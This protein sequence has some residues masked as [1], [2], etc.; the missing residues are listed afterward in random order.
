MLEIS[1]LKY[2]LLIYLGMDKMV[3]LLRN[4][5]AHIIASNY[6]VKPIELMYAALRGNT[7]TRHQQ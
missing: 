4:R 5:D 6:E 3:E 7:Y 2:N 1:Q